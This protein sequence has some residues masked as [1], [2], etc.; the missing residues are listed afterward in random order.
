MLFGRSGRVDTVRAM[1]DFGATL[2]LSVAL[3]IAIGSAIGCDEE[4]V[5]RLSP[6]SDSVVL[7]LAE[8]Y[9]PPP[10]IAVIRGELAPLRKD[11]TRH[12]PTQRRRL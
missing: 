6:L 1:N 11:E 5:T 10:A 3:G 4:R 12:G 8:W 9:S 2:A 7:P